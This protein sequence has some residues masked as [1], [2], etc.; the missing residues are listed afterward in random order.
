MH[1]TVMIQSPRQGITGKIPYPSLQK[2]APP[3]HAEKVAGVDKP[4]PGESLSAWQARTGRG[5]R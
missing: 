3:R 4:A 1:A 2:E 5:V